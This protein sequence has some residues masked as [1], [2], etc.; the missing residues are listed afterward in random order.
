[1]QTNVRFELEHTL[2]G[3]DMRDDL[4]FPCMIGPITGSENSSADDHECIVEIAFH[5]SAPMGVDGL[6]GVWVRDRNMV[7]SESD[8]G[9]CK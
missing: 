4:A 6:E 3:E 1:M 2:G 7:W 8:K 9:S 5:A